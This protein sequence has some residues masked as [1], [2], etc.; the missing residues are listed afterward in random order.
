MVGCGTRE[1]SGLVVDVKLPRRVRQHDRVPTTGAT[2]QKGDVLLSDLAQALNG[3]GAAFFGLLAT[4][5][6][7]WAAELTGAPDPSP[8]AT[9]APTGGCR[10]QARG[11]I[12][13][14]KPTCK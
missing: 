4:D 11:P 14:G 3:A 13:N 6:L 12:V 2:N 1:T 7:T 8:A 10:R 9:S 5:G